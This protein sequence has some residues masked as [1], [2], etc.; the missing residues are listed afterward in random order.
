MASISNTVK[1]AI[2]DYGMSRYA[3]SRA[4]GVSEGEPAGWCVASDR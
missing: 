2:A 3:I 1:R 4:T